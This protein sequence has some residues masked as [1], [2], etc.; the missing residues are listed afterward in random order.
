M[1]IYHGSEFI[2]DSPELGKGKPYND[3]GSGFYCTEE[4]E[5]AKEWSCGENHDGFANAY[6]LDVKG[7]NVL[8]LNS[9]EYTVLH[10]LTILLKNRT[11]RLTNPIAKDAKKYLTEHFS[12]NTDDYDVIIGNRAD[13]SYFSFAEDFLNNTIS[14]QKLGQAMKLGNLGEQVVLVSPKAFERITFK[15]AISANRSVYYVLRNK[16]D[17]TARAAYLNSNRTAYAA[18]E[19]YI[20]DII[21]QGVDENDPRLR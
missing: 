4:I 11:F 7:L 3:Y 5:L 2:I 20:L 13:D 8:N 1:R 21:R 14:V 12:I 15:D 19:L 16:R 18:D 10:W 17:K 9:S 6:D